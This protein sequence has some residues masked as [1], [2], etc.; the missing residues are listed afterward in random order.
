[1]AHHKFYFK[2]VPYRWFGLH[3]LRIFSM[4]VSFSVLFE[5]QAI[6]KVID[7]LRNSGSCC[8]K[9]RGRNKFV[10]IP[11]HVVPSPVLEHFCYKTFSDF[12]L[13]V[14]RF[15]LNST[16]LWLVSSGMTFRDSLVDDDLSLSSFV[17]SVGRFCSLHI[18]DATLG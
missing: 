2:M 14:S 3:K 6:K 16:F 9:L 15:L 1:M 17:Y 7:E 12:V 5:S 13:L 10:L 8:V 4:T 18:C 11:R